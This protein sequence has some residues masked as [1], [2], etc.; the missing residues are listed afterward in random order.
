MRIASPPNIGQRCLSIEVSD[1][2]GLDRTWPPALRPGS[3]N[4]A[5]G[6]RAAGH[7]CLISLQMQVKYSNC[8]TWVGERALAATFSTLKSILR[9]H[10]L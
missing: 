10:T 7:V 8:G 4:A 2:S 3:A 6:I 5:G 1:Q 9:Q